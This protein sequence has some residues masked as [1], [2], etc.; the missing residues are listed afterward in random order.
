MKF[1]LYDN[2]RIGPFLSYL[3]VKYHEISFNQYYTCL[4]QPGPITIAANNCR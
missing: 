1:H 4:H 3:N 2:I